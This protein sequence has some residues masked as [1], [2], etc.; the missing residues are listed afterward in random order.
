[1]TE[2]HKPQVG[3]SRVESLGEDFSIE[4]REDNEFLAKRRKK[5]RRAE[6]R[7]RQLPG[8][9]KE[10]GLNKVEGA[11]ERTQKKKKKKKRDLIH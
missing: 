2:T 8:R 6:G 7:D 4:R 5:K 9:G 1:M 10:G 3:W 11:G